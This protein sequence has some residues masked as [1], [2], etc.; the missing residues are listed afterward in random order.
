MA[1]PAPR[2][3]A[4][5]APETEFRPVVPDDSKMKEF[6][7][8]AVA[9]GTLLGLVF[10]ASS[11]YLVMKVG[12][13]VSASIPVAVLSITLFRALSR[14]IGTRTPTILENNITQTAGSAG[15]SIAF[16]VGVTM[17]GLM[18]LGFDMSLSRVMI[19]SVL[20]GLLGILMMIPLRRAFIVRLHG[21]AG[22]P[23]KL[24][25]PEGTACATVL[26]TGEQGGTSGATVAIGFAIAFIHKLIVTVFHLF[27]ET[28]AFP[29]SFFNKAAVVATDAAG[30]L[31]GV[32]YIIGFRTSAVMMA[33]AVTGYLVLAPTINMF[34]AERVE[35]GKVIGDMSP[36][37]LSTHYIK[38]IGAGCVAAAGIISMIRTL[39]MIFRTIF[40]GISSARGSAATLDV[41]RTSRD[42]PMWM[43]ISGA[44]GLLALL[45]LWL[46]M[47]LSVLSS[48]LAAVLVLGFGF[49]FVTVSSRLTGE[50]GSSSNPISGMTIATLLVTCVIFLALG[51]T[52]PTER[53]LALSIGA[54]VCIAASNG[55]TTS[56]D[57]KTGFL[58]GGTPVY[59]QY[60]ILIGALVSALVIGGTLLVFN[61]AGTI[62]ADVSKTVT[63]KTADGKE[64]QKKNTSLLP[65]L[66]ESVAEDGQEKTV[67]GE[68][69]KLA[70]VKESPSAS[71]EDIVGTYL[72]DQNRLVRGVDA[73]TLA[74]INETKTHDGKPFHVWRP[75]RCVGFTTATG[76]YYLL[77]D[78]G[79]IRFIVDPT[80]TGVLNER[81][82]GK[83]VKF[84]FPA[85]KTQVMAAI[86]NS[87]LSQRVNWGLLLIGAMIAITLELCG[88]S[89]LAFAVGCYIPMQYTTP[90]FLGG[91]VRFAVDAWSRSKRPDSGE[92]DEVAEIA[93]TETS[94]GVLLASGLIAGGSLAG[95][96]YALLNF[97]PGFLGSLSFAERMKNAFIYNYVD[98]QGN[99]LAFDYSELLSFAIFVALMFILLLY[100]IKRTKPNPTT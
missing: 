39:P 47:E 18:L 85:P 21:K 26:Q 29:L 2:T 71:K 13:T 14:L 27:K 5:D 40:A 96:L 61:S 57:L 38:Y 10:G 4:A 9:T 81:D 30:E 17:P 79:M 45:T 42:M 55:G 49:L 74:K 86:I 87:V 32:G 3:S 25:Y 56:Q 64:E 78:Q 76:G 31:L 94:P 68:T 72:I 44:I 34:G 98:S 60:A 35:F 24:L 16:G 99:K 15:E 22:E 88:V 92:R 23:G 75:A 93:E 11:L 41:K 48:V 100:G 51:M 91:I 28:I 97:T 6:T 84:K 58:V 43:V 89:S 80:I 67:E 62:V 90:I 1:A 20:G 70:K 83:E 46:S 66:E 65:R 77:D 73:D 36:G 19:V 50:I 95:V 33:G 69:L 82:D 7:F 53:V 59:Q 37:E 54:V 63:R 8:Q 52:G 12:M